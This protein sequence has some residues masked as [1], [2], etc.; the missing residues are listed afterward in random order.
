MTLNNCIKWVYWLSVI[1]LYQI[2]AELNNPQLSFW[3]FNQCSR[4]GFQGNY[5]TACF[6]ELEEAVHLRQIWGIDRPTSFTPLPAHLLSFILCCCVSKPE[7]VKVDWG[8]KSRPNFAL[9]CPLKKLRKGWAQYLS[10][11][12]KPLSLEHNIWYTFSAGPL[13]GLGDSGHY[14]YQFL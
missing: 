5:C 14:P 8:R 11:W 3:W 13:R 4:P 1:K 10:R 6:S 7:R 2:W 12:F 9:F